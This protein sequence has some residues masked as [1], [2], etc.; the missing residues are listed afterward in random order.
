ML[1]HAVATAKFILYGEHFVTLKDFRS[2]VIPA[3]CFTTQVS[4][5]QTAATG[6]EVSCI[7]D[8]E[9]PD[10][11]R[12]IKFYEA[13]ALKLLKRAVSLLGVSVN[14]G[15]LRMIVKSTI[16]PGQG[17]GSSSALCQ[18]IVEAL[19]RYHVSA[20][21]HLNYLM[22]FGKMLE[23]ELHGEVSGVDNAAIAYQLPLSYQKYEMCRPIA[24]HSTL[25][26]V[27]AS[28]GARKGQSPYE[29][30][31]AFVERETIDPFLLQNHSDTSELAKAM[32]T[33]NWEKAGSILNRSQSLLDRIG[34]STP[35]CNQAIEIAR[36]QGALGAKITGAGAGGFVIALCD[37]QS[38]YPLQCAWKK[39]GLTNVRCI[40][41]FPTT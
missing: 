12:N 19:L 37:F 23:N 15:G 8:V 36:A 17:A 41:L 22:F 24:L 5:Y 26:F 30:F 38:V 16:P 13:T 34:L 10:I 14:G 4:L 35:E 6:F 3:P 1:T 40:Q 25:Y 28:T 31:R 11:A 33:S 9:Q 21:I 20:D 39:A 27:V 7:F 2:I 18:A 29:R 32:T